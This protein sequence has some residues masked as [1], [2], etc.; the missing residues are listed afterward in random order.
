MSLIRNSDVLWYHPLD[1]FT[2]YIKDHVWDFSTGNVLFSGGII[3]SGYTR[4]STSLTETSLLEDLAGAGY[5]DIDGGTSLTICFWASGFYE[6][7]SYTRSITPG[8]T[9]ANITKNGVGL[10]K[11]NSNV[12]SVRLR[13]NNFEVS[14]LTVPI[15]PTDSGWNFAVLNVTKEGVDWRSRVSF[16]GSG[17]QDLGTGESNAAFSSNSRMKLE[18]NDTSDE[19]F[20]IDEV[21]TWKDTDL[22]TSTELS[23]LYELANTYDLSMDQY[24]N[25]FGTPI[26]SGISCF[27][28]GSAQ[29]EG[30]ATLFISAQTVNQSANLSIEGHVHTSGNSSLYIEGGLRTSSQSS[31][32][33]IKGREQISGN[34]TLFI[35]GAAIPVSGSA[36]LFM[37]GLTITSG[38]ASLY[39]TGPVLSSDNADC[40]INGFAIASGTSTLYIKGQFPNIDAI[41]SVVANTP[42][43]N[44]NLFIYGTP[45]GES[46]TFFTNNNATLFIKDDGSDTTVDV[47]VSSFVKVAD[48]IAVE[49]S[50][51]WSSF[52]KVGNISSLS[53]DFYINAHASGSNPHGVQVS[54]S[55]TLF[56]AGFGNTLDDGYFVS[57]L[58][59]DVFTRVHLGSNGSL[60]MYVS[61]V[62]G[63]VQTSAESNLYTFGIQGIQSGSKSLYVIG[64]NIYDDSFSLFV[65]GIQGVFSGSVP[66]YLEVTNIGLFD[67]DTTLYA[68]GF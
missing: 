25:T 5:T 33:W 60:D 56:V 18:M 10:W 2:E 34:S 52:V 35:E 12:L 38:S 6:N 28:H 17:W 29:V 16:N 63:V 36:D 24:T 19:R 4:D 21:V 27:I 65:F 47:S 41:V 3:L 20:V 50:G 13:R 43:I 1:D 32:L 48:A 67:Q 8:W 58:D 7:N 39:I 61:G 26:S 55:E 59:V 15:K 23:N 30:S 37:H 62:L 49:I 66:L 11:S 42:T 44:A 53:T 57:I 14:N 22:F 46:Q 31:T 68:H 45:S 40:F 54:T 64:N 9:S 51:T